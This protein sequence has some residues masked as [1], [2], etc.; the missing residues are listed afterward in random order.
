MRSAVTAAI[1]LLFATPLAAQVGPRPLGLAAVEAERSR[2]CVD[3]LARVDAVDARLAPL[4]ARTQRLFAAAQAVALEDQG[5]VA[6]LDASDPV[7]AQVRAWFVSDGELAQ[8]W[9]ANRDP[10]IQD[11]RAAGREAIKTAVED[12]INAIQAEANAVVEASGDLAARAAPCDGAIFLRGE[13]LEACVA[14]AGPICEEAASTPSETSRFRFVDSAERLWEVVELQP[15]TEPTVLR[16]DP[17]GQLEGARTVGFTR[18]G[19]VAISVAFSPILRSVTE[20]TPNELATYISVGDSLGLR[21]DHPDFAFTPALGLR[22]TLPAALADETV[23]VLHFGQAEDADVLWTGA[24]DTGQALEGSVPL[25]V[26]HV[27]RLR[28]G[29][30]I[31]LTAMRENPDG[32]NEPM[33]AIELTS[34]YQASATETLM[35]YMAGQL[36]ADLRRLVPPSG[37]DL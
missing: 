24:A 21:F 23:Y 31:M 30:A 33:F 16:P 34:I 15:W 32:D 18:V 37:S 1:L 25:G 14:G 13:V 19:N 4:V 20:V 7:E 35:T 8:R 11:E 29:D 10:A 27:A 5:V 6:S 26:A 22:A 9:V 36:S 2:Q 17:N 28:A 3:V 12:A